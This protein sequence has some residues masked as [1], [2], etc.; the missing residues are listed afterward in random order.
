MTTAKTQAAPAK[1][2]LLRERLERRRRHAELLAGHPRKGSGQPTNLAA[3]DITGCCKP[4]GD[5]L[6][7]EEAGGEGSS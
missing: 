2:K 4:C 5:A 3:H 1:I 7:L 6:E